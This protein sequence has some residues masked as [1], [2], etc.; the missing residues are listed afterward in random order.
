MRLYVEARF[1]EFQGFN[2]LL[3][4]EIKDGVL[5]LLRRKVL[6]TGVGGDHPCCADL[7]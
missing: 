2:F 4:K 7:I 6:L 3:A 5:C 1:D